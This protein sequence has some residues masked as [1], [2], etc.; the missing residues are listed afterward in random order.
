M[1]IF[2]I[3]GFVFIALFMYLLFKDKRSDI[4]MLVLLIAGI[5]I[6][7]YSLTKINEILIFINDISK[8]AGIN[9]LYIGII[10]KVLA[11]A[12]LVSFASEICKDS[13][14]QSLGSKVELIGKISIL[15]LAIPI[16]MAVLDSILQIL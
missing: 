12:Y 8:K 9:T 4:S 14:A 15:L 10:L 16:L 2:K 13:G 5:S 11:I 3:I 7:I 6:F 1:E